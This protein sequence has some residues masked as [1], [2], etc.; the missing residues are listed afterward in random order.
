MEQSRGTKMNGQVTSVPVQVR[1]YAGYRHA[2]RP[3]SFTH[4]DEQIAIWTIA[5]RWRTPD[6][7]YFRV[8]GDNGLCY[9]LRHAVITDDWEVL[10]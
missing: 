6:H 5:E 7:A 10:E 4:R 1:C 3:C 9:L 8:E 2:E